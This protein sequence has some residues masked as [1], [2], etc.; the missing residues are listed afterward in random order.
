M[1]SH[2]AT[3][4]WQSFELRMRRRRAERLVV[5][6]E[7]A[8]ENGCIED[9][10]NA[11]EE[12]RRLCPSLPSLDDVQ[13]KAARAAASSQQTAAA[14]RVRRGMAIAAGLIIVAGS[15]AVGWRTARNQSAVAAEHAASPAATVAAPLD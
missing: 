4:E 3:E 1:A 5:R 12:A 2:I 14:A 11:L 13:A 9:A 15:G 6:A 8:L 7:A 10:G